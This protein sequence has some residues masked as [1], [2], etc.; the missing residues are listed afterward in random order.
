[1]T[2]NESALVAQMQ[3]L[4]YSQGMIVTALHILSNSKELS[5]DALLYLVEEQ[6]SEED[7]ISYISQALASL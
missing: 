5:R 2:P 1:M 4:D 3:E 7:F 6:P